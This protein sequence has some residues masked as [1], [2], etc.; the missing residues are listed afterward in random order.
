MSFSISQMIVAEGTQKVVAL[1]WAYSNSDGTLSN[2]HKL[3]EPY[4]ET[5]LAQCTEELMIEWLESQLQNTSAE[6]DAAIQ[7]R[8][9]QVAFEATLAPYE[10]Q[11][12]AAPTK[13]VPAE[14]EQEPESPVT[15][16]IKSKRNGKR[17]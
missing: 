10:A 15:A 1:N 8:K 11:V 12:K 4:G 2:Q 6:F 13:I 5:P 9:E 14:P 16:D 3:A 7:Q 17:K